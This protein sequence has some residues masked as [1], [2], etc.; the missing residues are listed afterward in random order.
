MYTVHT[1]YM[2]S[3]HFPRLF[4]RAAR[5]VLTRPTEKMK[6]HFQSL[7]GVPRSGLTHSV[8]HSTDNS[9]TDNSH[10]FF[11]SQKIS[12]MF[13]EA[14]D[15]NRSFFFCC[16][17]LLIIEGPLSFPFLALIAALRF[18]LLRRLHGPQLARRSHQMSAMLL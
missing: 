14:Q 3:M 4:R 13:P 18:Q 11:L 6:L 16:C 2:Y 10:S 12:E 15:Q 17:Q 7:P 9:S 1:V 5:S 8:L